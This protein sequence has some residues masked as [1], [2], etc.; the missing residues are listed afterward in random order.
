MSAVVVAWALAVIVGVIGSRPSARGPVA[1]R[2]VVSGS[3]W[4]GVVI[5]VAIGAAPLVAGSIEASDAPGDFSLARAS[6][7]VEV[8]AAEPH[9]IGSPAIARVRSYLID[10]LAV[11]GLEPQTQRTTAPDYYGSGGRVSIVNVLAR[12][13][14]SDSTGAVVLAAHYDT[15]PETPGANDDS[16]GVA[17]LL[18]VARALVL[19]ELRNDVILLFTDGEEPAPRYGVTSFIERHAWFEDVGF[20]VNLEAIGSGGSSMVSEIHGSDDW[21]IDRVAGSAPHPVAF[22]FLTET[23]E[24]I[25]GSKSDFGR[26]R[27]A[28]VPGIEL[29]YVRGSAIYHTPSDSFDR[30]A[31]DSLHHHGRNALGVV[32][33]IAS[34]DLSELHHG[35]ATF[36]TVG[37]HLVVRYPDRLVPVVVV[38][39]GF[40]L[41][42]VVR[43]HGAPI[44]ALRGAGVALAVAAATSFV[45]TVVWVVVAG[46]RDTMD[47]AESNLYL[48]ALVGL[49]AAPVIWSVAGRRTV[50]P[51]LDAVGVAGT[52][53]VLGALVALA[54]PGASYLFALPALVTT[55]TLLVLARTPRGWSAMASGVMLV[56]LVL[57]VP[58]IDVFYQ[59]AQPRPGNPSSQVLWIVTVP[60]L[61]ASL[62]AQLAVVLRPQGVDVDGADV[63]RPSERDAD[64]QLAPV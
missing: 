60:V 3:Y 59:F 63:S 58:A 34:E 24:L 32:R 37:R 44:G 53:W 22:S 6:D 46:W 61:L 40:G 23:T 7:H 19:D 48:V 54:A 36:F 42:L 39:G 2:R 8:V 17:V 33:R 11:I 14:G 20:V 50:L 31:R 15:V 41:L 25:G 21:I 5:A 26:F 16:S 47:L 13:E 49:S 55:I 18:E 38:L 9:P 28:G 4:S 12:I 29:V 51:R 62:V 43:R 27:E 52:W 64:A 56:T 30:L 1:R 10:E 57:V 35:E 45:L